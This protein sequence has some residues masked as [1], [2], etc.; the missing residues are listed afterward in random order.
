MGPVLEGGGMVYNDLPLAPP[1]D[2]HEGDEL[3]RL[4]SAP[5]LVLAPLLLGLLILQQKVHLS[6]QQAHHE[7]GQQAACM[8]SGPVMLDT[9]CCTQTA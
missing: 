6:K 9:S 5:A 3:R 7:A 1:V 8:P 4:L 2:P